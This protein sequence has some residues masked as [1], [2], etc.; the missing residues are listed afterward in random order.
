MKKTQLNKT[1]NVSSGINFQLLNKEMAVKIFIKKEKEQKKEE[2]TLAAHLLR[3]PKA[4]IIGSGILSR[5]PPM[6]KFCNDL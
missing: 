3:I 4:R 2:E 5:S 6:S 1:P